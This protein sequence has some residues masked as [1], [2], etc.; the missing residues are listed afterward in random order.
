MLLAPVLGSAQSDAGLWR[1][2]HPNAKAVVSIDWQ[3]VKQSSIGALFH[4]KFQ[5]AS[6]LPVT[7]TGKLPEAEMLPPFCLIRV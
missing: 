6:P 5:A 4:E 7:V 3:R 1:W 2:V